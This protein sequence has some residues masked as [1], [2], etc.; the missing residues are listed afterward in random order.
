MRSHSCRTRAARRYERS[1]PRS[2]LRLPS[3]CALLTASC[4]AGMSTIRETVDALGLPP[5]AAQR[6]KE[7]LISPGVECNLDGVPD[8][9]FYRL[10]DQQ[11]REAGLS[12]VQQRNLVL[13]ELRAPTGELHA[14]SL[15]LERIVAPTELGPFLRARSALV[16]LQGYLIRI[17]GG[18]E[19]SSSGRKKSSLGTKQADRLCCLK[20]ERW[21][22]IW[23]SLHGVS[24]QVKLLANSPSTWAR[25]AA[26]PR[27]CTHVNCSVRMGCCVPAAVRI[28]FVAE[29]GGSL[30]LLSRTGSLQALFWIQCLGFHAL[31][32][33]VTFAASPVC[34]QCQSFLAAA[35]L[36][37]AY[38]P[39]PLSGGR[40]LC[41]RARL[42]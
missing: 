10:T 42:C 27:S 34:T 28:A 20:M 13:S 33:D 17:T 4:F 21:H 18:S 7:W 41:C 36:L 30:L 35:G 32:G 26:T 2:R 11:L 25:A 1:G 5:D 38:I 9:G 12:T 19:N 8:S 23:C 40:C 22:R 15:L 31:H 39:M 16:C 24:Q 29:A 37:I 14:V 3:T 6:L